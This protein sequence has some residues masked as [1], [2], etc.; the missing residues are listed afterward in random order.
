MKKLLTILFLCVSMFPLSA[1]NLQDLSFGTDSTFEVITWNIE[2]F[3]K[4]GTTTVDSVRKAL[5]SL[6]ADIIA[7]Q[8]IGDTNVWKQMI[9][10][11]P[12]YESVFVD[13]NHSYN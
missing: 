3:P 4:N 6:D 9:A 13:R 12:D 8:E 7:C 2:W 1:Q 5:E 10:T 11:L